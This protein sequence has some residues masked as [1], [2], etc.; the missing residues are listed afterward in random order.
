MKVIYVV[1]TLVSLAF[2]RSRA[3]GGSLS[4][5]NYNNDPNLAKAIEYDLEQ[6]GA[7]YEKADRAKAEHYYLAYLKDVNESFQR[8]RVYASVGALYAVAVNHRIGEKPDYDKARMYFQKVL[9]LEPQR[10]ASPT[11]R[12]RTMLASMKQ[13]R[14]ARI[15]ARM[16]VYEWVR[17][18]NEEKIRELWLPLTPDDDGPTDLLM[19]STGN[20]LS[21][22][23]SPL[24]TNIMAGIKSLPPQEAE[25]YLLEIIERFPGSELDTLAREKLTE[26]G[27]PIPDKP[28]SD[29]PRPHAQDLAQIVQAPSQPMFNWRRLATLVAFGL[30]LL[31]AAAFAFSL[32]L[33]RRPGPSRH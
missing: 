13:S 32:L 18:I 4:L 7:D 6:N 16:D 11:I 26:K 27:I 23:R 22:I 17:S 19:L 28:A 1:A 31:A 15:K 30:L 20:L 5:Q 12:A 29:A 21:A 2:L 3:D 33:K 14:P 25:Q 10:I 24:K 8:A 9:E